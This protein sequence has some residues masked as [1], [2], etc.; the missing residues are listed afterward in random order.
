MS[1]EKST[2][3]DCASFSHLFVMDSVDRLNFELDTSVRIAKALQDRGHQTFFTTITGLSINSEH[4]PRALSQA[5][6]FGDDPKSLSLRE[7]VQVSLNSFS[8]IHM[9]KDP[10][11]DEAYW[12][13]T[14]VLDAAIPR[15]RRYNN[16]DALRGINEKLAIFRF[17]TASSPGLVSSNIDQLLE[18]HHNVAKGDS[19]I[20]PLML[21]GGYGVERLQSEHLNDQELRQKLSDQTNNGANTRII[22]TFNTQIFNGEIR[23]FTAFGEAITWCLKMP[24][25]GSYLANSGHGSTIEAFTPNQKLKET[26]EGIAKELMADGIYFIGF[27]IIGEDISEINITS[28]RLLSPD[29]NQGH[30]HRIAQLIHQDL[31]AQSA[32]KT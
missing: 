19:I 13:A 25:E 21:Y 7:G 30:F 26:T 14:W 3:P 2:H 32:S 9:R 10:P 28:P 8:A 18:F 15:V 16:F 23:A 4:G 5:M 17:P 27:D 22:Q 20:K 11:T 6:S 12:T 24:K 29:L 1:V 31:R